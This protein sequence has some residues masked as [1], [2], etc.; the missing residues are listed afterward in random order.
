[1]DL[2]GLNKENILLLVFFFL[3]VLV[4]AYV[5]GL[6]VVKIVDKRLSQIK[7]NI[8]RPNVTVNMEKMTNINSTTSSSKLTPTSHRQKHTTPKQDKHNKADKADKEGELPPPPVATEKEQ[9]DL[10]QHIVKI[11]QV[12]EELTKAQ[13]SMSAYKSNHTDVDEKFNQAIP[14]FVK[15]SNQDIYG[16]SLEHKGDESIGTQNEPEFYQNKT[17]NHQ[18]EAILELPNP[19]YI[20]STI[21]PPTAYKVGDKILKINNGFKPF[22]PYSKN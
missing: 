20:G 6:V 22:D 8:P 17:P 15:N 10:T 5:L 1:M 2:L 16:H 11:K 18:N 7:V 19:R 3:L 14:P 21:Q 9:P 13:N 4:V 12:K